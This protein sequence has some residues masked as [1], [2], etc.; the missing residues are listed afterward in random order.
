GPRLG[1]VLERPVQGDVVQVE[2]RVV[3][4]GGHLGGSLVF[5]HETSVRRLT[6]SYRRCLTVSFHASL[7]VRHSHPSGGAMTEPDPALPAGFRVSG[8][9][10]VGQVAQLV[11][12]AD[13]A[14]YLKTTGPAALAAEAVAAASAKTYLADVSEFQPQINDAKYLAWSKAIIIRAAYG[15]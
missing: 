2:Q 15:A 5:S 4:P 9:G 3:L 14:G 8:A 1:H 12:P 11:S 6:A 7:R 10:D 13:A